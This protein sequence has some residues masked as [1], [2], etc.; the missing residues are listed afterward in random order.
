MA[1]FK[2]GIPDNFTLDVEPVQDLGDY[3]DEPRLSPPPPRSPPKMR[4]PETPGGVREEEPTRVSG[5]VFEPLPR[6]GPVQTTVPSRERT[7][8]EPA[9]SRPKGPRREI[10][11]TPEA[12]SMS[13]ELLDLI[14]S[15]TGQRD[16]K[17]SEL[18]HALVLLAHEVREHLELHT[19]PKRGRWGSP[20]ARAYP[21]SLKNA[22]RQTL[23][24]SNSQGALRP[25]SF[26][27]SV[28]GT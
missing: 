26:Q 10:S 14:R 1:K 28:N 20:T 12:L 4:R 6:T 8:A 3:L 24:K 16:T 2:R 18:F 13:D 7:A 5:A 25:S 27:Y 21:V 23:Q 22:I 15:G 17:A 11:M 9:A 19:I